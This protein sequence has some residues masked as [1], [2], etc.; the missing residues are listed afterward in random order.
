M[1]RA[2]LLALILLAATAAALS[3]CRPRPARY[4]APR[5]RYLTREGAC[6]AWLMTRP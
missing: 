4:V 3:G 1:S 5:R 2:A 6:F